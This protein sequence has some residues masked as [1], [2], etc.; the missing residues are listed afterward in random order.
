VTEELTSSSV[1]NVHIVAEPG[2]ENWVNS[3]WS[4]TGATNHIE[5][6]PITFT[7]PAGTPVGNYTFNVTF[8]DDEGIAMEFRK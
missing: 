3:A 6:V 7:V 2:Y 4:Y 5:N 1:T 8:V